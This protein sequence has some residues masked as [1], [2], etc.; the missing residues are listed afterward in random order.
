[1]RFGEE[2]VLEPHI[3]E[4]HITVTDEDLRSRLI[5]GTYRDMRYV[6]F[7]QNI[8]SKFFDEESAKTA[9]GSAI[10][11]H[12][13]LVKEWLDLRYDKRIEL[14]GYSLKEIGYGMAKGTD[15][16]IH[17][18]MTGCKVIL[19]LGYNGSEFNIVSAYPIPS[20]IVLK[21]IKKDK[22]DHDRKVI[23]KIKIRQRKSSE[24]GELICPCCGKVV[25]DNQIAG[26]K[27]GIVKVKK[28][29]K[30]FSMIAHIQCCPR[31]KK[32]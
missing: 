19:E 5:N 31:K 7:S 30:R 32:Q 26:K 23:E 27:C 9:I 8:A 10:N 13:K 18:P 4:E 25:T 24:N 2:V 16:N 28:G 29:E 14:T 12:Q 6:R 22:E 15:F 20:E 1:M 21:V 11:T 17:Y 3:I